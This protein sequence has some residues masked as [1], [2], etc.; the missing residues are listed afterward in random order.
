MWNETPNK[1]RL[2]EELVNRIDE[3]ENDLKRLEKTL[4]EVK[5]TVAACYE[6]GYTDNDRH[7]YKT[8][9]NLI[10]DC[11]DSWDGVDTYLRL[12]QEHFC[13]NK[14]WAAPINP[15]EAKYFAMGI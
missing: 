4:D 12:L 6:D 9:W 7:E 14:K 2:Q 3:A 11:Y 15:E 10:D 5:K 1:K 8:G 13:D